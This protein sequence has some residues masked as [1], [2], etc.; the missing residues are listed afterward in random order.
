[1][2][3]KIEQNSPS[4]DDVCKLKIDGEMT[5]YVIA[6]LKEDIE[7]T[8]DQHDRFELSLAEV[9]EIDSA[10]VQL[11]FALVKE[12]ERRSKTFCLT[13]LSPEVVKL[14]QRYGVENRFSNGVAA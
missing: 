1:M 5:I 2:A 10:G 6:L 3:L 7:K 13:A 9:E 4:C 12:L 14:F 11:L 8:F